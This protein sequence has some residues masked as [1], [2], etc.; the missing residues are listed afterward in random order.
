MNF[1]RKLSRRNLLKG[2]AAGGSTV[3]LNKTGLG[4]GNDGPIGQSARVRPYALSSTPG[5]F[6]YP[7]LTTGDMAENG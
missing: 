3:L 5:V 2:V 6:I 4:A 7:I 1:N